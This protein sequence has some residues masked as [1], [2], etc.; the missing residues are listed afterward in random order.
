MQVES[1]S[2]EGT[3]GD[4]MTSNDPIITIEEEEEVVLFWDLSNKNKGIRELAMGVTE[5]IK[6]DLEVLEYYR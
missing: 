6:E 5:H 2:N 4:H 3:A 1:S